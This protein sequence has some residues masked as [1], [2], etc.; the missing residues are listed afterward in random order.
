MKKSIAIGVLSFLVLWLSVTVARLENFRYATFV[1]FCSEA[2]ES[3]PLD[4]SK[5][6]QCLKSKETR[7]NAL[8]H[9]FYALKGDF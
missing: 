4:P 5:R 3:S 8:W 1:G 2:T 6:Y 7:T 9:L